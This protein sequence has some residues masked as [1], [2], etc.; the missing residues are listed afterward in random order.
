MIGDGSPSAKSAAFVLESTP[1][2]RKTPTGTSLDL[3]QPD[4]G[5]E[6]VEDAVG[7]R[8]LRDSAELDGVVPRRPSSG[9]PRFSRRRDAEPRASRQLADPVEER[10]RRG[11]RKEREVVVERLLVDRA[12]LVGVLEQGLD[13]RGEGQPAMVDAPVERLDADPVAHKPQLAAR[14]SQSAN[15]NMPRKR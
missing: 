9:A 11:R 3:A 14:S 8:R 12:L 6:L 7:D 10:L 1:P 15:A 13:L 5:A 4:R 2:E